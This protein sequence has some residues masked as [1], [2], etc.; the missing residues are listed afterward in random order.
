MSMGMKFLWAWFRWYKF[1]HNTLSLYTEKR[2]N[3]HAQVGYEKVKFVVKCYNDQ[4]RWIIVHAALTRWKL[5]NNRDFQYFY[6]SKQAGLRSIDHA[7]GRRRAIYSERYSWRRPGRRSRREASAS[8]H[9]ERTQQTERAPQ[10]SCSSQRK[11]WGHILKCSFSWS[12]LKI[13]TGVRCEQFRCQ[14]SRGYGADN[15]GG[16]EGHYSAVRVLP[17]VQYLQVSLL[18][19]IIQRW[20]SQLFYMKHDSWCMH[21]VKACHKCV[22]W[23]S[24]NYITSVS[25]WHY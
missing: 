18:L 17:S 21:M 22:L 25:F 10:R 16:R 4:V 12:F 3:A 15:D 8:L 14:A 23:K 7:G 24:Y 2:F 13:L 1:Y 19:L 20:P 5:I 9:L 11:G 6:H